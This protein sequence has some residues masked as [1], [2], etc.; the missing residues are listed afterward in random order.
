MRNWNGKADKGQGKDVEGFYSTYEELKLEIYEYSEGYIK[1]FLQYLW[2][3]ETPR[4]KYRHELFIT[5]F[6]STYE[7]LKLLFRYENILYFLVFTVPMRNW[8]LFGSLS[9]FILFWF[10]QYLWGIETPQKKTSFPLS[11]I[12]FT[13]PMRNWNYVRPTTPS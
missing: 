4:S 8:N 6:Y 9:L 10:L 13:V 11:V 3:I 5:G 12:V 7:E 2:G 1:G